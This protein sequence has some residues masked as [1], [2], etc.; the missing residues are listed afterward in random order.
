MYHYNTMFNYKKKNSH[1]ITYILPGILAAITLFAGN[2]LT[3][4]ADTDFQAAAQERKDLPIQTNEISGWPEGPQIG[5]E[6]A[7]LL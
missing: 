7:I 5:A 4:L 6:A 3:C 2:T 1:K